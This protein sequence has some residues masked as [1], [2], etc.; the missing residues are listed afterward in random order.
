M[1]LTLVVLA[2]VSCVRS[3]VVADVLENSRVVVVHVVVLV[4]VVVLIVAF[5]FAR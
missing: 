4:V 5:A 2:V 3:F 1:M